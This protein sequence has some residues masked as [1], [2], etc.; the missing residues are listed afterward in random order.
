MIRVG[1]NRPPSPT[2][3][4]DTMKSLIRAIKAVRDFSQ[5]IRDF[6]KAIKQVAAIMPLFKTPVLVLCGDCGD[7]LWPGDGDMFPCPFCGAYEPE[8]LYENLQS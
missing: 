4:G 7:V 8:V 2:S 3:K 6:D 1:T 5:A